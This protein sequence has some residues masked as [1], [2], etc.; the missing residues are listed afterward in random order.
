VAPVHDALVDGGRGC[1]AGRLD[2]EGRAEHRRV[3][4]GKR[5]FTFRCT[6]VLGVPTPTVGAPPPGSAAPPAAPAPGIAEPVAFGAVVPPGP[7]TPVAV[8][9]PPPAAAT[10]G[11]TPT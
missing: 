10:P 2:V 6:R 8:M 1:H 3:R 11:P 9:A 5:S 4:G 7:T